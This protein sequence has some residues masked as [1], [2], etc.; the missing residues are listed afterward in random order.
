MVTPLA[1]NRVIAGAG[2][3]EWNIN[4]KAVLVVKNLARRK[5]PVSVVLPCPR[6]QERPCCHSAG[7]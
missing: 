7:L 6:K 3:G 4:R 2:A 1:I 5:S